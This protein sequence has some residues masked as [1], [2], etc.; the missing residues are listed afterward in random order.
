[1]S[2]FF[3]Q[4][5]A[6]KITGMLSELSTTQ[7]M[8]LNSNEESLRHRVDE[9]IDLLSARSTNEGVFDEKSRQLFIQIFYFYIVI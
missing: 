4:S 1:M 2:T 8:L 6:A 9:A 7:L 5:M 3:V